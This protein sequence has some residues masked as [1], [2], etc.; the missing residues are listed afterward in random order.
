MQNL[1]T[2]Q[3]NQEE[4]AQYNSNNQ[5]KNNGEIKDLE[6]MNQTEQSVQKPGEP[7]KYDVNQPNISNIS[8]PQQ[9]DNPT[10]ISQRSAAPINLISQT[11][12][13][14]QMASIPESKNEEINIPQQSSQTQP[15]K[16]KEK[17]KN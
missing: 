14:K 8:N 11:D 10:L 16:Q 9:V 13:S 5:I 6:N 7:I 1:N 4:L 15:Q 17:K 2:D 12:K 3:Y